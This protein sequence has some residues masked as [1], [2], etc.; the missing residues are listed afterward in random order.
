MNI[1]EQ[2]VI[3][4]LLILIIGLLMSKSQGSIQTTPIQMAAPINRG[5]G[6][7]AGSGFFNNLFNRLGST[8]GSEDI[9]PRRPATN[10]PPPPPSCPDNLDLTFIARAAISK[11]GLQNTLVFPVGLTISDQ[12]ALLTSI[13]QKIAAEPNIYSTSFKQSILNNLQSISDALRT[14]CRLYPNASKISFDIT[15]AINLIKPVINV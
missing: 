1:N 6:G 11:V 4:F 12:V 3:I 5:A 13:A 10:V 8:V 15:S 9:N 2:H 7:F 14:S